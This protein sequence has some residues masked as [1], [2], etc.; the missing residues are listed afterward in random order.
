M[1][2]RS[3]RI[4]RVLRV[5]RVQEEQ[6]RAAWLSLE[7][8]ALDAEQRTDALGAAHAAMTAAL[9]EQQDRLSP[10]WVLLSHDQLALTGRRTADQRERATTHRA[11]ADAA[12]EPWTERRAATR[13]LERLVDR[14]LARE[15]AEDLADEARQLDELNA[16]RAAR[17][18]R[19]ER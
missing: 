2:R 13:G 12:R 7:G 19:S 8:T 10:A 5:R 1:S 17:Q 4:G 3:E 18:P 9:R 14:A 15:R 6:A 16:V 11:Q